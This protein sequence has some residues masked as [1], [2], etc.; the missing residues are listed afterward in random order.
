MQ[1]FLYRLHS[2]Q[3]VDQGSPDQAGDFVTNRWITRPACS[4]FTVRVQAALK[5]VDP[6][7]H[8]H[9]SFVARRGSGEGFC[10]V[11]QVLGGTAQEPGTVVPPLPGP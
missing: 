1:S 7:Q 6:E 2:T 9:L 4:W 11:R 8:A 10:N 3:L 5:L